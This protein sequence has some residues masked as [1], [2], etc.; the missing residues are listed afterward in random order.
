MSR[1]AVEHHADCASC[2]SPLAADQRYCLRCGARHGAP[3]V[4]P[5]EALG[6]PADA[7]ADTGT[8]PTAGTVP[9]GGTVPSVGTVPCVGPRLATGPRL[10]A[11]LAA[12]TLV[13]GGVA[14]AAIG[15]APAP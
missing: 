4:D 9:T 11:A 7:S 1:L 3:R 13:L 14:G 10:T 6:F 12:A 2:G 15:P 5:L 8:V